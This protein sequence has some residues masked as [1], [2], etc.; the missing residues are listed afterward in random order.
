MREDVTADDSRRSIRKPDGGP[1]GI[2]N[3]VV[4][5]VDVPMSAYRHLIEVA[6]GKLSSRF[7]L[8]A[9]HLRKPKVRSDV[10]AV[11]H[12]IPERHIH[13]WRRRPGPWPNIVNTADT[14]ISDAT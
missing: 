5:H 11:D 14:R 4:D 3:E 6:I 10:C 13:Q 1:P 9:P 7:H 8:D 12:I 2:G